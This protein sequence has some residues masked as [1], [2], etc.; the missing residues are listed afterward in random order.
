[1]VYNTMHMIQ[2]IQILK[3]TK[4]EKVWGGGEKKRKNM[5]TVI[6]VYTVIVSV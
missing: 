1:M 6:C 2:T 4:W 5:L 3:G